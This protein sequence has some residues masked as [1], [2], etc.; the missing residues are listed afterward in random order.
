MSKIV[1]QS[2]LGGQKPFN[3]N[4][5][6]LRV[7]VL[8]FLDH[9]ICPVLWLLVMIQRIPALPHQPLFSITKN[10]KARALSYNRLASR[11]KKWV[12]AVGENPVYFSL[13]SLCRGRA[14]FAHESN[15]SGQIIWVLGDWVND[16]HKKCIDVST[17]RKFQSMQAFVQALKIVEI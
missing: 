17:E 11:L 4:R 3:T 2:S 1:Y 15:M 7:L 6:N 5:E 8:P 14:F 12:E 10:S 16:V 13:H 9:R